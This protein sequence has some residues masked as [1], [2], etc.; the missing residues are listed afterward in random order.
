MTVDHVLKTVET[1]LDGKHVQ[2]GGDE[3]TGQG[4]VVVKFAFAGGQS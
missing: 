3:T 2:F 4:W 1:A